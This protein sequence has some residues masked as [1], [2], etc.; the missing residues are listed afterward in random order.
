MSTVLRTIKPRSFPSPATQKYRARP[1]A[2]P[3][4]DSRSQ[5]VTRR[6]LGTQN[7]NPNPQLPKFSFKELGASRTVK[8]VVIVAL[9][10]GGTMESIFWIQMIRAKFFQEDVEP[11]NKESQD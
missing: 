2:N 6:Q 8:Y 9:T 1:L 3:I 11:E 10:I 5:S 4:Q 7:E